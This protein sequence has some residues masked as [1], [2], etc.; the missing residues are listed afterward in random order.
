M[1]NYVSRS[2]YGGVIHLRE[3][4]AIYS[5]IMLKDKALFEIVNM[6]R[7]T[8]ILRGD[9]GTPVPYVSGG[10]VLSRTWAQRTLARLGFSI[11]KGTTVRNWTLNT[12]K[13]KRFDSLNF[14]NK[15]I[16]IYIKINRNTHL[17]LLMKFVSP[18]FSTAR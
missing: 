17:R 4:V 3:V 18:T 9:D 6:R 1:I 12:I 7:G 2:R 16:F 5:A 10:A 15:N 14:F 11:R 8:K 13:K